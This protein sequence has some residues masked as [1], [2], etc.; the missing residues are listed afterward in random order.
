MRIL[1]IKNGDVNNSSE[2]TGISLEKNRKPQNEIEIKKS[3]ISVG[4]KPYVFKKRIIRQSEKQYGE[5]LENN[6]LISHN[7]GFNVN[8]KRDNN[9]TCKRNRQFKNQ[10]ANEQSEKRVGVTNCIIN[11]NYKTN[12]QFSKRNMFKSQ[13]FTE[14]SFDNN[15]KHNLNFKPMSI[16]RRET[17]YTKS[18]V[19][20]S[21]IISEQIK[22]H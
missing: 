19:N 11:K 14:K 4:R 13:H 21:N 12:H 5:R 22:N 2:K 10:N 3:D 17:T 9:D 7:D 6:N 16:N 1:E 18:N 20:Y 8:I 15:M